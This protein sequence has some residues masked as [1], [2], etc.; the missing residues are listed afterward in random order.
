MVRYIIHRVLFITNS[1]SREG[2]MSK[3]SLFMAIAEC[4]DT[5]SLSSNEYTRVKYDSNVSRYY[6][7]TTIYIKRL[8]LLLIVIVTT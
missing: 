4:L 6:I 8:L 7:P 5:G 1:K 2:F 3:M